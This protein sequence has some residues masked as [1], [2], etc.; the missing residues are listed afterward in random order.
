[1]QALVYISQAT[2]DLSEEGV[3]RIVVSALRNNPGFGLTGM[4]LWS[5]RSFAQL[6]EGPSR[7]LDAMMAR[8]CADPR[9][10]GVRVLSRWE[11]EARLFREWSM[12]SSRVRLRAPWRVLDSAGG[13]GCADLCGDILE[14]MA[15]ARIADA[16]ESRAEA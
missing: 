9:H 7:G 12:V 5:E 2:D 13:R 10:A 3:D 1:M 16:R 11:S 14:L 15:R 6:L 8:I 4:L